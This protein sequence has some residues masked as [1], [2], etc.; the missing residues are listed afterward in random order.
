[1]YDYNNL[2]E[3][4]QDLKT[5]NSQKNKVYKKSHESIKRVI[6]TFVITL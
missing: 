1:M 4:V 3:S 6:L 5:Q 2:T